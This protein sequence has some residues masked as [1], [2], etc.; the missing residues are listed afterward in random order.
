[1]VTTY[2]LYFYTDILRLELAAISTLFF[3]AR[4]WDAVN[5]PIMGYLADRTRS[6]WG[7]FRPYLLF[8]PIFL[9]GFMFLCFTVPETDAGVK[10]LYAYVTYILLGMSYTL[11][12]MPYGAMAASMT[13]NPDERSSL[14]GFRMFF[15]IIGTVIVSSVTLPLVQLFGGSAASSRGF[16]FTALIF[17]VA[18]LPLYF[19]V[20]KGTREIVKPEKK[21]KA[22]FKAMG[23]A[24]FGNRPLMLLMLSSLLGSVCMF[25]K[26]SMLIYYCTYVMGN[27]ALTSVLLALMAVM[28]LAG[29]AAAAP[30]SKKLGNKKVT[31]TIGL[32]VSGL[33]CLGMYLTGPSNL[34]FLYGWFIIGSAFSGLT[35]VMTWSMVS[36]TI[37]YA[38]WKTGVRADGVIYSAASFVQKLATAVSGWGAAFILSVSGYVA[39]AGQNAKVLSGINFSMTIL[40]GVSLLIAAVPLLFYKLDRRE[41]NHIVGEILRRDSG[42]SV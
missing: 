4:L 41:F 24:V 23:R 36:D 8:G 30:V 28:M 14:S 17:A 3:I 16:S 39:S 26:Q 32:M 19:I 18:M 15:A 20:F 37:E 38:E 11:V 5:D 34:A 9:S 10:L 2:L 27:A 25:I 42:A 12:N 1:M 29:I 6:R 7:R 22:T 33:C 21:K 35:Y 31:M 13:Q 40:P